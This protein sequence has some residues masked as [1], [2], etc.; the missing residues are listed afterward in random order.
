MTNVTAEKLFNT[1]EGEQ[2]STKRVQDPLQNPQGGHTG[3]Q[4]AIPRR[5]DSALLEWQATQIKQMEVTVRD[6]N[7]LAFKAL[8]DITP[9]G[10][11]R[12]TYDVA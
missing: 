4:G 7:V 1:I 9:Q 11:C 10:E 2:I 5:A 12:L 8:L 6:C 3:G